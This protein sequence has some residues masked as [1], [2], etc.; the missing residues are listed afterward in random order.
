MEAPNLF[1]VP[2]AIQPP[3]RPLIT[4]WTLLKNPIVGDHTW[5]TGNILSVITQDSRPEVRIGT[6]IDL[7][8]DSFAAFEISP[9]VTTER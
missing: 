2:S 8:T 1:L 3:V 9:F 6:K 5:V 4:P 7:K